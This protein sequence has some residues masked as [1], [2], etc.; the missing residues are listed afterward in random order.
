MNAGTLHNLTDSVTREKARKREVLWDRTQKREQFRMLRTRLCSKIR[1][2]SSRTQP[3]EH[4]SRRW[5]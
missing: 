5:R 3:V 4:Q 1:Q 2:H